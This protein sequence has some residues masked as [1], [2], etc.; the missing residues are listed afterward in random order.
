LFFLSFFFRFFC[1]FFFFFFFFFFSPF[2]TAD[3][4]ALIYEVPVGLVSSES[5][6]RQLSAAVRALPAQRQK[7]ARLIKVLP[8][9]TE[10]KDQSLSA[11]DPTTS[12]GS[13][14]KQSAAKRAVGL[15]TKPGQIVELSKPINFGLA[16][17]VRHSCFFIDMS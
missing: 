9:G 1:F 14:T 13:T 10:P 6:D 11:I 4:H 3:V 15:N 2:Q 8:F 17:Q 7:V 5:L 12:P 16:L